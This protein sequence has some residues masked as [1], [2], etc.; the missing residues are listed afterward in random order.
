MFLQD[1]MIIPDIKL[2]KELWKR[3]VKYVAGI[4]EAGRG[5]LAGPVCAGVV[6]ISKENEILPLIRD[7]KTMREKQRESAY[8]FIIHNCLAYGVYMISSQKIDKLGIQEAVKMAIDA[9]SKRPS[10]LG[11]PAVRGLCLSY[12]RSTYRLNPIAA[13]R[14]L[15]AASVPKISSFIPNHPSAATIIAIKIKGS[16]KILC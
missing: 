12:T 3:G 15:I 4:D 5:P 11:R 13:L 14:A 7:S 8:D 6:I 16:E 9:P 1:F 10:T 2:E